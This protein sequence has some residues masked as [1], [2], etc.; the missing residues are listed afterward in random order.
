VEDAR[1]ITILGSGSGV[2]A[3]EDVA[4]LCGSGVVWC[5][6]GADAFPA[7]FLMG[8][9]SVRRRPTVTPSGV[10]VRRRIPDFLP[11]R[12]TMHGAPFGG[13]IFR[14]A[15]GGVNMVCGSDCWRLV[16]GSLAV[17]VCS[18]WLRVS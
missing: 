2:G 13:G 14:G 8:E 16:V 9:R 11:G 7:S 6:G 10:D 4:A 1:P 12:I 3:F 15:M 17:V 5:F 18:R